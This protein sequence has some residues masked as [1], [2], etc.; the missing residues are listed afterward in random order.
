MVLEEKAIEVV[1]DAT[2]ETEEL[3]D[4]SAEEFNK[5]I[6][7]KGRITVRDCISGK[8]RHKNYLNYLQDAWGSHYGVVMSPDIF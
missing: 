4:S 6:T 2:L 3:N 7:D 1:L 5:S 8:Y